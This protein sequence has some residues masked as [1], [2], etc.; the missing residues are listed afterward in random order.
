VQ[1]TVCLIW[2]EI[3]TFAKSVDYFSI[4]LC[5]CIATWYLY[6]KISLDNGFKTDEASRENFM[7]HALEETTHLKQPN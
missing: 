5:N 4:F 2:A 3:K 7:R 6:L 1:H